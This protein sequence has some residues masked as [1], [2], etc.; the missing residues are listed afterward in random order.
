MA[1]PGRYFLAIVGTAPWTGTA[2]YLGTQMFWDHAGTAAYRHWLE[3]AR[4]RPLWDRYIPEGNRGH[5]LML[6]ELS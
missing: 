2:P 4:L 3:A 1:P 5:T 6:A